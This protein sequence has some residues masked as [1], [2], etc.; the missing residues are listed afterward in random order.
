[1]KTVSEM[2]QTFDEK[3]RKTLMVSEY[4]NN[5]NVGFTRFKTIFELLTRKCLIFLMLESFIVENYLIIEWESRYVNFQRL[6]HGMIFLQLNTYK[7]VEGGTVGRILSYY[8]LCD[9]PYGY[10]KDIDKDLDFS[11]FMTE[12]EIEAVELKRQEREQDEL[13]RLEEEQWLVEEEERRAR[14]EEELEKKRLRKMKMQEEARN[15]KKKQEN[16]QPMETAELFREI[17]KQR[18]KSSVRPMS[19]QDSVGRVIYARRGSEDVSSLGGKPINL[20]TASVCI[21]FRNISIKNTCLLGSEIYLF[22]ISVS[23]AWIRLDK[24]LSHLSSPSHSPLLWSQSSEGSNQ[25]ISDGGASLSPQVS[26]VS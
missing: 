8:D 5:D 17:N 12:D 22:W 15:R 1:M 26:D 14:E 25:S 4:Y 2:T 13:R 3:I 24:I 6:I 20:E 9:L 10:N 19:A 18:R 23:C 11:E 16:K 21:I 7:N